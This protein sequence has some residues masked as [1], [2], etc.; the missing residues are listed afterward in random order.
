MIRKK[1][2]TGTR[3][4]PYTVLRRELV[5]RLVQKTLVV[6]V[7]LPRGEVQRKLQGHQNTKL[8]IEQLLSVQ[9]EAALEF[10][11][12]GA[13]FV[14]FDVVKLGRQHEAR[15]CTQLAVVLV[16]Q[17]LKDEFLKEHISLGHC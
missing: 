8:E 16:N 3:F 13:H 12:E 10:L 5:S 2:G 17:Q 6:R 7:Y 11:Y 1:T 9:P 14:A 4:I 15:S